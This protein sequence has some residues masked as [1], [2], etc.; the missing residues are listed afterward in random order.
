MSSYIL[1][2]YVLQG[3]EEKIRELVLHL[4]NSQFNH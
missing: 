4:S 2:A 1:A 3:M